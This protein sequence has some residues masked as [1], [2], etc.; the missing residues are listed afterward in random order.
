MSLWEEV[1]KGLDEGV[2]LLKKSAGILADKTE[3]AVTLGRLK[4]SIYGLK[5]EVSKRFSELGGYVYELAER[6]EKDILDNDKVKELIEEVKQH[7]KSI[8][9]L[10]KEVEEFKKSRGEKEAE[11]E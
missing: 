6:G 5:S 4:Y 7:E 11:K 3:E 8:R 10:E 9:A 2:N 1:Q